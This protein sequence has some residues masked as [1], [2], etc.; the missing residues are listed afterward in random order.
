MY[1]YIF[2]ACHCHVSMHQ[3]SDPLSKH[4]DLWSQCWLYHICNKHRS[5]RWRTEGV[6]IHSHPSFHPTIW[7]LFCCM[8]LLLLLLSLSL[9]PCSSGAFSSSWTPPFPPFLFFPL[10]LY[11]CLLRPFSSLPSPSQLTWHSSQSLLLSRHLFHSSSQPLPPSSTYIS[12]LT[13]PSSKRRKKQPPVNLLIHHAKNSFHRKTNTHLYPAM[14]HTYGKNN[15][16]S[17][18]RKTKKKGTSYSSSSRLPWRTTS[19]F[20]F[21]TFVH[22]YL[23]RRTKERVR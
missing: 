22:A 11:L 7:A 9:L 20:S 18:N 4:S 15:K 16:K 3:W 6:S 17:P 10:F 8:L 13:S 19:L 21:L 23:W 1:L 14:A 5:S 2:L 12:T